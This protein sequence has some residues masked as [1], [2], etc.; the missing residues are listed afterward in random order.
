M[1]ELKTIIDAYNSGALN[2]EKGADT[3]SVSIG[4]QDIPSEQVEQLLKALGWTEHRAPAYDVLKFT[5]SIARDIKAIKVDEDTIG[6]TQV[7]FMNKP[8]TGYGKFF[9]RVRIK[10]DRRFDR[11][12]I[13]G[14][15][16]S[17]AKY[18]VYETGSALV[19]DK[20]RTQ[21]GALR[22]VFDLD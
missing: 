18:A 14:M 6:K 4:G 21:K 20:E 12:I 19:G 5:G 13:I 10:C 1:V 8:T 9:E 3:S 11:T 17:P 2:V 7:E 15:Y 22:S 16:G